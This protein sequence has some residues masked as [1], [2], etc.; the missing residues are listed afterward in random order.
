MYQ[1]VNHRGVFRSLNA[2]KPEPYVFI[3]PNVNWRAYIVRFYCALICLSQLR[4]LIYDDNKNRPHRCALNNT[5]RSNSRL[6]RTIFCFTYEDSK[7]DGVLQCGSHKSRI[8]MSL[9]RRLP[10]STEFTF[11]ITI[12]RVFDKKKSC[13]IVRNKDIIL[14][15]WVIVY[16]EK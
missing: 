9:L 3:K 11:D 7:Q 1:P 5:Q 15:Y 14:C 12:T 13:W 10:S 8:Y 4:G 2:K 16:Y 6:P